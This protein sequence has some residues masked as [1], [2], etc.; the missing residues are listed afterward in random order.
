MTCDDEYLVVT[1]DDEYLV[2]TCDL[3]RRSLRPDDQCDQTIGITMVQPDDRNLRI[4]TR[5]YRLSIATRNFEGI[6]INAT[7]TIKF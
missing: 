3:K 5:R 2:E 4:M 6:T 1:C 7:M